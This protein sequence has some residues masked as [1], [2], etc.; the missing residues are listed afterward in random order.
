MMDQFL[1][2]KFQP[3]F[4]LDALGSSYS[5]S[6]AM[7]DPDDTFILDKVGIFHYLS[8]CWLLLLISGGSHSSYVIKILTRR[9]PPQWPK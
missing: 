6:T 5:I 8:D 9:R 2:D 3:A 4:T 1:V 7:D